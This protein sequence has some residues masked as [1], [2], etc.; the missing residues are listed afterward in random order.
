MVRGYECDGEEAIPYSENNLVYS[1]SFDSD[2][3]KSLRSTQ[4]P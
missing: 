4:T 2:D 3:A 1:R